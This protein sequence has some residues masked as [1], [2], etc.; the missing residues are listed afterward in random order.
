MIHNDCVD[1]ASG[2]AA[3]PRVV[4]EYVAA[5][6]D[7]VTA[8]FGA[9]LVG[10][11]TTGSL[12]LGDFR[13]GRSDVDLMAVVDPPD[14]RGRYLDLAAGLDHSRLPCPAAGLEFVLYPRAIITAPTTDAGYLLN[15][16][17]GP[18]LPPVMSLDSV[19]GPAFW[20]VIDRAV[21]FQ[22]GEAVHG[23]SPRELFD[24][25]P[26]DRLLPVVL[27][28]VEAQRPAATDLLD[29]VVLNACRAL[30]F[31]EDRHWYSKLEAGRRTAATPDSFTPLI[32]AA[33]AAHGQGRGAGAKLPIS[34]VGGFVDHVAD[35]LR[36]A[37]ARP[38][39]GSK[40]TPS[41]TVDD[42][43]AGV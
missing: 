12:A 40:A 41:V 37:G 29:N 6:A 3:A 10:V 9:D 34:T 35:A 5:V 38:S 7:R 14:D 23:P 28:A 15:L 11:Y 20:F 21:T 17:T 19:S 13:L 22:S 30:R 27:A 4:R 18:E 25:P 43:I 32:R 31:T 24:P 1:N 33:M 2:L 39:P 42:S 26:W 36:R 16:N 8:V